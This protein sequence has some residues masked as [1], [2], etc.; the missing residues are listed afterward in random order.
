MTTS[1]D[2]LRRLISTL[3]VLLFFATDLLV[4]SILVF[5]Y[6]YHIFRNIGWLYRGKRRNLTSSQ[7]PLHECFNIRETC[8]RKNVNANKEAVNS[9]NLFP[10][11]SPLG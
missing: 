9:Y 8:P 1:A 3:H 11:V 5:T 7:F 4:V 10:R 6:Q 2:L